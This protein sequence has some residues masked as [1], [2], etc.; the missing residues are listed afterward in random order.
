MRQLADFQRVDAAGEQ[1]KMRE[2]SG[3]PA[4]GT[5]QNPETAAELDFVDE[6]DGRPKHHHSRTSWGN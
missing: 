6:R 5:P 4:Y 3:A 1:G 2:L